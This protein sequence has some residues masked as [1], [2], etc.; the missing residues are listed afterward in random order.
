MIPHLVELRN[1]A[2]PAQ[3]AILGVSNEPIDRLNKFAKDFKMNYPVISHT[4]A[5][6]VP[7]SKVTGLPTTFL[8]DSAG[9]IRH[10]LVGYHEMGDIQAA[11]TGM[12]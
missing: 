10:V 2:A 5:M 11:L 8:I 12:Q 1:S 6:P 4:G 7:Y 3:L 9:V